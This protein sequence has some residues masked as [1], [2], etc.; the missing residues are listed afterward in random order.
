MWRPRGAHLRETRIVAV[1]NHRQHLKSLDGLRGLAILLVFFNHF[2][3]PY[4]NDPLWQLSK[5]GWLGVD[6]FFVLSGFLITGILYDTLEQPRFFRNF[7]ARRAL[8]LFPVYIAVVSIVLA[9]NWFAG[10]RPTVWAIP[11]F[12]YASNI[13]HDHKL[14]LGIISGIEVSH[15]WSLALEEQFY[16]FWPLAVFFAKTKRQILWL[17]L[18]GSLFAFILRFIAL[19][20]PH[21]LIGTPYLELPMRL[22]NLLAG[23]AIAILLRTARGPALLTPLRLYAGM[24]FGLLVIGLCSLTRASPYS[25]RMAHYGF[26]ADAIAFA[27]LIALALQ[28][29]SWASRL[30]NVAW[31]RTFGRYSYGLYLIH[32]LPKPEVER[33]TNWLQQR[34]GQWPGHIAGIF[35]FAAY[36]ALALGV[37]ALSYHSLELPLLRLK[38]YFAYADEKKVHHMQPDQNTVQRL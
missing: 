31:L 17:C 25:P 38:K 29:R 15:L 16:M 14:P 24:G 4:A 30:G 6:L 36:V 3:P 35:L 9:L 27:S 37:A 22:D 33:L 23:G 32:F 21:H 13:V 5:V 1:L 8:R 28:P 18:A 12:I 7:Y 10:G 26:L 34:L 11:F 2:Y 20:H 19:A